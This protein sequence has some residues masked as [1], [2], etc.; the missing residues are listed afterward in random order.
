MTQLEFFKTFGEAILAA[1]QDEQL[2][3][4]VVCRA[5]RTHKRT[6]QMRFAT[7]NSN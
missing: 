5:W 7:A 1:V 6:G 4:R 3:M 2:A